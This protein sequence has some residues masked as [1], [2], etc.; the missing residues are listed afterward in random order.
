MSTP[1]LSFSCKA[2]QYVQTSFVA[3]GRFVWV[4]E[5]RLFNFF[6]TIG[7]CSDCAGI[8]AIE[9]IPDHA[10][11]QRARALHP[12]LKG[13]ISVLLKNDEAQWLAYQEHFDLLE[14]IMLQERKPACLQCGGV[15]HQ[16]LKLPE[17]RQGERL[18]DITETPLGIK[19]PI[20]GGEFYVKGSGTTRMRVTPKTYYFDLR[21]KY[22]TTLHG[23]DGHIS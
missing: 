19:H 1:F 22:L 6:P 14:Q 8:V 10:V 3:V 12:S 2:C 20:C 23:R 7:V 15:N 18:T 17:V 13:K 21:G 16:E 11:F 4:H 9:G 5:S